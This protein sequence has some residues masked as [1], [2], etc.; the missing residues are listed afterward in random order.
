MKVKVAQFSESLWPHGL[1][2]LQNS[3][4]QNTVVSSH[5]FLQGIFPTQRSNPGLPHF[6]E[7]LYQLRHRGSPRILEWVAYPFSS[8]SSHPRKWSWVSWIAGG[9]LTNWAIRETLIDIYT[10]LNIKMHSSPLKWKGHLF[11]VLV[12]KGLV[13]LHRTVQVK[14][15]LE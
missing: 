12:L 5:S 13:G 10:L 6:R 4:G 8:R 3:P 15:H 9:F 11:W 14:K 2:S 1:Y 7:I